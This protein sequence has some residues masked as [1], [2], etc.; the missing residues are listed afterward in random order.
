MIS[1]MMPESPYLRGIICRKMCSERLK[2]IPS[3]EL[4]DLVTSIIQKHK[5]KKINSLYLAFAPYHDDLFLA[6]GAADVLRE[7]HGKD[8]V[9]K[10]LGYRKPANLKEKIVYLFTRNLPEAEN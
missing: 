6:S 10:L 1:G 9:N 5:G 8:Y 7:R 3:N 2:D 4:S